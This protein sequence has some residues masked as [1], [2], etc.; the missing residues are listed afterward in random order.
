M[1]KLN[2]DLAAGEYIGLWTDGCTE[3]TK[4]EKRRRG[5]TQ[6]KINLDPA[7]FTP[8]CETVFSHHGCGSK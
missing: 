6:K 8:W 3:E 4:R 2:V 5:L 1:G 7:T